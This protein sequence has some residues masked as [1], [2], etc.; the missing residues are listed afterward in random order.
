[1]ISQKSHNVGKHAH[2]EYKNVLFSLLGFFRCSLC[3]EISEYS[4]YCPF[5]GAEMDEEVDDD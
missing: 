5:C 4:H 3:G 2:W 1:M